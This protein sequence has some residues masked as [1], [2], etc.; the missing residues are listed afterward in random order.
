MSDYRAFFPP[1]GYWHKHRW[2]T[3]CLHRR[4]PYKGWLKKTKIKWKMWTLKNWSSFQVSMDPLSCV[5]IWGLFSLI[6]PCVE[7]VCN[8]FVF[9]GSHCRL[10][11]GLWFYFV[12]FYYPLTSV[13]LCL[14]HAILVELLNNL[15]VYCSVCSFIYSQLLLWQTT[16]LHFRPLSGDIFTL[17]TWA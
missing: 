4:P 17:K 14:K 10:P 3:W 11:L 15:Y 9:L 7:S 2:W 12:P 1:T 8:R 13:N 5:N 6:P 16:F